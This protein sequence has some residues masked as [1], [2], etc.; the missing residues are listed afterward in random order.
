MLYSTTYLFTHCTIEYIFRNSAS[1]VILMKT[2]YID[3]VFFNE[4]NFL[5]EF[6]F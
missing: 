1:K 2:F 4:T 5:K 3:F 6:S